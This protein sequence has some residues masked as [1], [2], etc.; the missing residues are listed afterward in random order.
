MEITTQDAHTTIRRCK[1]ENG[2]LG[3]K[4]LSLHNNPKTLATGMRAINMAHNPGKVVDPKML[5]Q[6]IEAWED[7]LGRLQA[8]YGETLSH[9]TQLAALSA[10]CLWSSRKSPWTDD[11]LIGIM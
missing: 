4:R 3:W 1:G 11:L 9:K 6:A 2:V 5:D 10:C 8:D 7:R